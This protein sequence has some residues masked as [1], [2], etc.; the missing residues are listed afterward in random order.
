MGDIWGDK[1]VDEVLGYDTKLS[2]L[3]KKDPSFY[4]IKDTEGSRRYE[5]SEDGK[6][7]KI[8]SFGQ[9]FDGVYWDERNNQFVVAEFKGQNSQLSEKQ[10]QVEWTTN[11]IRKTIADVGVYKNATEKERE[12]AEEMLKHLNNGGTIRHE[13]IRTRFDYSEADLPVNLSV[14]EKIFDNSN[15][16]SRDITGR[17]YSSLEQVTYLSNK[18]N[19]KVKMKDGNISVERFS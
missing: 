4:P 11:V 14:E 18:G 8:N 19:T 13:V 2:P 5:Y 15:S 12:L 9:G 7:H 1:F 16:K 6:K 3:D 17:M 10:N